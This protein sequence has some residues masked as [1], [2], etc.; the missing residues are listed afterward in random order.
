MSKSCKGLT[1]T[2]STAPPTPELYTLTVTLSTALELSD[3]LIM[4]TTSSIIH[5][6]RSRLRR[7]KPSA[8]PMTCSGSEMRPSTN[9]KT[10][11]R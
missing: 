10:P 1:M 5:T 7:R 8:T 11:L 4:N 9:E 2:M 6:E 3:T